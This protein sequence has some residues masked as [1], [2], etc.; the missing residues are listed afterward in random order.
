MTWC[1]FRNLSLLLL[2]V[3]V[4]SSCSSDRNNF[5][6]KG[7]HNTTARYNA[8]F[9]AELRMEDVEKKLQAAHEDDYNKI[10]S[11]YPKVTPAMSTSVGSQL[12]DI[13]KKSSLP[14]TRHKNSKWVDNSYII[15]GK[16]RRYSLDY[17][18]AV[19]TFKYVNTKSEDL[20]DD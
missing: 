7:Y 5:L 18:E 9:L 6:S 3:A 1:H 13:V 20:D 2:F 12:E 10:L 8:Y 19:S 11:I 4:V 16:A 14:I 15:I 17:P